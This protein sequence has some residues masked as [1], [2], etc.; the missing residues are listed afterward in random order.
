MEDTYNMDEKGTA[1]GA[2]SRTRVICSKHDLKAYKAQD[3]NR[4]EASLIECMSADGRLLLMFLIFKRKRH[5]KAWYEVLEDKN[6]WIALSG[7]GWTN[8]I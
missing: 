5:M 3:G 2:A 4:E 1:L 7:N 8:N 6:V